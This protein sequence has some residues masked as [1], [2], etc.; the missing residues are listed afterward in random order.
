MRALGDLELGAGRTHDALEQLERVQSRLGELGI[1]DVDISPAAELVDSYLRTGR[2]DDAR[3]A[4]ESLAERAQAKGQPWSLA[5]AARCRGLLAGEEDFEAHFAEALALHART[6]DVFETA[7]TQLAFGARLR[8]ARRRVRAREQLRSALAT[9]ESLGARPMADLAEAELAATGETA[10]RRDPSTLDQLT[11]QE[12]HIAQ[13]LAGGATTREAAAALF[14]SPK[15]I[16]YHLRS[17]YRKVGVKSRD[18]LAE[19]L[20]LSGQPKA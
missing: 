15:T 14:L 18:A 3:A 2:R 6:P 13:L 12:L 20:A 4:A 16:E 5:R 19:A 1:T 17:V 9:F 11:P 10:R 8:R 7:C